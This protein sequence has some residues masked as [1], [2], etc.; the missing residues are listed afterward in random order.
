MKNKILGVHLLLFVALLMSYGCGK[1][2]KENGI[3]TST[4]S[5]TTSTTSTTLIGVAKPAFSG[6][7]LPGTHEVVSLNVEITTSTTGAQIHF[8]TDGSIPNTSSTLYA[9]PINLTSSSTISAIAILGSDSSEVLTGTF[10]I[11]WWKE[12]GGGIDG[13]VNTLAFDSSGNLYAGGSFTSAGGVSAQNIAMWDG[14]SWNAMGSGLNGTVRTMA[15]GQDGNLYVGG[16]FTESD[17]TILLRIASWDGSAWQNVGKGFNATVLSLLSGT[18]EGNL[19][20][21]AAGE[22]TN[23]D[24]IAVWRE[25]AWD[26][27]G[28]GS[29]STIRAQASD[30]VNLYAGGD[31]TMIGSPDVISANHIALFNIS[32]ESWVSLDEGVNSVVRALSYLSDGRLIVGGD[33]TNAGGAT[34]SNIAVWDTSLS[35]WATFGDGLNAS[36][37]SIADAGNG[38]VYAGGDFTAT[39]TGALNLQH[40]T[41]W[42]NSASDWETLGT[43]MNNNVY[44]L[45]VD[46]AGN[47]YAGGLFTLA[48]G[49]S[50][51]HIAV[52]GIK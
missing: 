19:F 37:R 52:W 45:A 25:E 24:H 1:V 51:S 7:Y 46:A 36:V 21:T 38:N 8:T 40:I 5:T 29:A 20:V 47:V 42:N 16:E 35:S 28:G 44:A 49:L 31:F 6:T 48:G 22:F 17:G 15:F 3:G 32:G 9:G 10:Y 41:R 12:L 39:G 27:I 2:V 26:Y 11:R 33:F 50:A 4:T 13:D 14:T 30:G 23:I 43:G 34:V 18:F